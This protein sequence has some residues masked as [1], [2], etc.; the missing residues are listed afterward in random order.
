MHSDIIQDIAISFMCTAFKKI[1]EPPK[2][3]VINIMNGLSIND[4]NGKFENEWD[5]SKKAFKKS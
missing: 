5:K 2:I 4:P 3:V 1:V